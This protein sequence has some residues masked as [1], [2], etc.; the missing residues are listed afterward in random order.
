MKDKSMHR[1]GHS[2][3]NAPFQVIWRAQLLLLLLPGLS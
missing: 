1:H 3:P 2:L